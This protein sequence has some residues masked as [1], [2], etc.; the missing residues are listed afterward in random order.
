MTDFEKSYLHEDF[1]TLEQVNQDVILSDK[2][3]RGKE[4]P[5][6]VKKMRSLTL[7]DSLER[8]GDERRAFRVRSCGRHL[9]FKQDPDT[10][11]MKLHLADF[12]RERLCP[13]CAWR[14]SRKVF[15][16]VSHVMDVAQAEASELVPVFLTLTLRNC[17]GEELEETLDTV[18]DGWKRLMNNKR[19]LRIIKG[20]FRAL[21]VTYNKR[22]DTFHPHIH[23]IIMVSQSY[24]TSKDYMETTAWVKTWRKVLRLDYDPVCDIRKVKDKSIKAVKEVAKYTVKDTDFITNNK[25]L[26][27]KLVSILGVALRGRR[28]F[29]FGGLLKVI[30]KRIGAEKSDDGDLVHVGEDGELRND[31]AQMIVVY[32]WNVG[33][34]NYHRV[35]QGQK[36]EVQKLERPGEWGS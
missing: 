33:L 5:W 3:N 30:A 24:F 25:N 12:C 16:D 4:R 8:L 29:A 9:T 23:A 6:R 13:M 2:D 26:T 28:L 20:W 10:R 17:S 15:Y 22:N 35:R 19:L 7:A 27:D 34:C 31:I 18:F 11:K 36:F 14:R 1:N 32:H 21:E